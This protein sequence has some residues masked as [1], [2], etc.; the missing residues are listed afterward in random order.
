MFL[1]D[2]LLDFCYN[3]FRKGNKMTSIQDMV[4][5]QLIKFLEEK[6]RKYGDL[7]YTDCSNSIHQATNVIRRKVYDKIT[8][9]IQFDNEI[10]EFGYDVVM[11]EINH[12]VKYNYSTL[13]EINE[14]VSIYLD[15][16][17]NDV[18]NYF[19]NVVLHEYWVGSS[20]LLSFR[21]YLEDRE[22]N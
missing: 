17:L 9:L 13:K 8:P 4:F 21:D 5:E 3:I 2:K 22:G 10:D 11:L 19:E 18:Q 6:E 7:E 15:Y 1:F 12:L 16:A 14:N 20:R